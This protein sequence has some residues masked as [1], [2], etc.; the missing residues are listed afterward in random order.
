[1]LTG[2]NVGA[3]RKAA[4]AA[5][6]DEFRANLLP[7]DKHA[8]VSKLQAEGHKVAM[9]GDGVNDAPALAA[10]HVSIAMSGGSAVA[11]EAA[12]ISLVSDNLGALVELRKLCSALQARMAAGY[13]FTIGHWRCDFTADLIPCP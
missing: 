7:E 6:V 3:A 13:R 8:L 2:D 1:M 5:G 10:A 12:D 4:E 9:I 11:R